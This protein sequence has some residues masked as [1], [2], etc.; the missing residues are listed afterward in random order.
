M[1]VPQKRSSKRKR[2]LRR[3][4]HA[5]KVPGLIACRNCTAYIPP[6]RVCSECGY[7]REKQVLVVEND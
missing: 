2:D 1:A 4:H 7:Y 5:L 6:H 3:S